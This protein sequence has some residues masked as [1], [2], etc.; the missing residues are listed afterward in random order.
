MAIETRLSSALAQTGVRVATPSSNDYQ[1]LMIRWSDAAERKAVCILFQL[2][3]FS[4]LCNL[5]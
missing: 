4:L 2:F 5:I 3:R 1:E